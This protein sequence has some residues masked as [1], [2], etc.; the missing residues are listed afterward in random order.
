MMKLFV[1][2]LVSPP[3]N[4]ASS[5]YVYNFDSE[6]MIFTIIT[7]NTIH[8]KYSEQHCFTLSESSLDQT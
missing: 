1:N 3:E 8:Y 7:H 2:E 6:I 5:N 4:W